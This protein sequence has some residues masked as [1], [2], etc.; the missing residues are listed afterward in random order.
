[1]IILR[2][3]L[4]TANFFAGHQV[5]QVEQNVTVHPQEN[6]FAQ[7]HFH[8]T[9]LGRCTSLEGTH[10]CSVL[11]DIV[12]V[13]GK[14]KNTRSGPRSTRLLLIVLTI[15]ALTASLI[16]RTFRIQRSEEHTSELQSLR[17]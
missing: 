9:T 4:A 7:W 14:S 13:M 5:W 11:C 16:T 1:M 15:F 8:E 10:C 12:T 6:V 3:E 2:L 17:H